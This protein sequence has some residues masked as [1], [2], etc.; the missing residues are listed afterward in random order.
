LVLLS[1]SAVWDTL[2]FDF[3]RRV[4][5]SCV[6]VHC[7]WA[8]DFGLRAEGLGFNVSMRKGVNSTDE[9]THPQFLFAIAIVN[10]CTPACASIQALNPKPKTLNPKP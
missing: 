3:L 2:L 8:V 9:T 4:Y 6:G 1:P 5:R 7:M 10:P